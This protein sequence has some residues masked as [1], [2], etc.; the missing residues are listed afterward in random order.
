MPL[1]AVWNPQLILANRQGLVSRSLAEVV[2]VDPDGTVT[3][4]QRYSGMLSQ[5][6]QLSDFPMDQH[7]FTIQ[8]A[9]AAYSAQELEFVPAASRYD[10]TMMV[11]GGIAEQLSL[12]DWTLLAY[13]AM[14]LPYQPVRE[15]QAAGFA[16]RFEARRR[17][18]YYLWQVLLPLS[19]VVVMSWAAFWIRRSETGVRIGVATSS[20]LTLI[21]HR[22]VLA[23]L[24]PRLPYMTRMDFFTV[25]STMLVTLA[26]IE[27]V[28]TAHLATIKRD[29]VARRVDLW[30]RSAFPVAFV[31]LLAWFLAG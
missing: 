8:F 29:E 30:A 15:V 25:G 31:A 14:T 12:Q 13:E 2:Q 1:E 10:P 9:S 23:S 6:L 28:A 3:Y 27:V 26:L 5:P 19:V 18:G 17:V 7:R 22:M 4:R 21:A 16:F 20:V 11:G 24:L